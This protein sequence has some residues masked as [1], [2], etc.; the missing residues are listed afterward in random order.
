MEGFGVRKM[1][2]QYLGDHIPKEGIEA[3]VNDRNHILVL[4][5]GLAN[6]LSRLILHNRLIWKGPADYTPGAGWKASYAKF[7]KVLVKKGFVK[8]TDHRVRGADSRKSRKSKIPVVT[9]VQ[10]RVESLVLLFIR[11]LGNRSGHIPY[12]DLLVIYHSLQQDMR[13]PLPRWDAFVNALIRISFKK[14]HV[15]GGLFVRLSRGEYAWEK[16]VV[17]STDRPAPVVRSVGLRLPRL[18]QG[19]WDEMAKLTARLQEI[20][21]EFNIPVVAAEQN[22]P[23]DDETLLFRTTLLGTIEE[24]FKRAPRDDQESVGV[25]SRKRGFTLMEILIVVAIVGIL[26]AMLIPAVKRHGSVETRYF[27]EK[28]YVETSTL[29]SAAPLSQGDASGWML[30]FENGNVYQIH[31]TALS[32]GP[33]YKLGTVKIGAKYEI[34]DTSDGVFI[35]KVGR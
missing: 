27:T 7:S 14:R 29:V 24:S 23:Q 3:W 35:R 6:G 16:L 5:Q 18:V 2:E 8:V 21:R 13:Y 12:P 19:K 26:V 20:A 25:M 17:N 34:Y 32:F 28:N 33:N 15:L 30:T 4:K 1:A 10:A 9:E 11:R 22:R 31:N